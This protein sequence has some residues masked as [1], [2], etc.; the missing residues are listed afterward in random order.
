LTPTAAYS[1]PENVGSSDANGIELGATGV[2]GSNWRWGLNYRLEAVADH[3][4]PAAAGGKELVDFQHVT[5]KHLVK[6]NLGWSLG[7][8]EADL[9]LLYQSPTLGLLPL[10][11]SG[12]VLT[13]VQGYVSFDGRVAYKLTDRA[14]LSLSGQDFAQSRQRQTSGPDVERRVIAS[15]TFEY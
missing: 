2:F 4:A 15:F 1:L 12:S 3:F 13:P 6:A 8:W 7:K 14:T 10:I 11:P 5:P 9:Y